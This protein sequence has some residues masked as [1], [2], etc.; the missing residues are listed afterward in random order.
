MKNNGHAM[1]RTLA[2]PTALLLAPLAA[3]HDT[4]NL[5]GVPRLGIPRAGSF[6][7]LE[8]SALLASNDW[9]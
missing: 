2:L 1:R 3:L 9:N 6:Q 8:T 5:P 4:R 7:A